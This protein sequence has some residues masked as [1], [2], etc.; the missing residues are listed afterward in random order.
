[1][2]KID[3][4][5][6]DL[7]YAN[8]D[9]AEAYSATPDYAPTAQH[10]ITEMFRQV[11]PDLELHADGTIR[12]GLIIRHL[13]LPGNV[14]NSIEVLRWIADHLSVDIHISLMS[15]YFPT[16]SVK[17]HPPLNRTLR[18]EEYDAV[19]EEF[20]RLGFH[21]GWVQEMQSADSYRPDFDQ[22]HPF[23]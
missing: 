9:L 8:N 21:R 2:G 16:D 15:Q 18:I 4:W 6:P 13:V 20:E 22:S 1:M 10:A 3:V 23:E 19:R 17:K 11:G 12:R 7:K 5:L 14:D